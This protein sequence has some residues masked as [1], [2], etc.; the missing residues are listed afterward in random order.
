MGGSIYSELSNQ[1][2]S[3]FEK[4][5]PS[6]EGARPVVAFAGSERGSLLRVGLLGSA[7]LSRWYTPSKTKYDHETDSEQVP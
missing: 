4:G 3:Y 6:I 2:K 7:A 1:S 5:Y